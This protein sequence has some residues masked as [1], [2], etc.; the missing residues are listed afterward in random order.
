MSKLLQRD[1]TRNRPSMRAIKRR[2]S[3][4]SM[5]TVYEIG[6]VFFFDLRYFCLYCLFVVVSLA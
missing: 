6:F 5:N 1:P 4:E 3:R 2:L